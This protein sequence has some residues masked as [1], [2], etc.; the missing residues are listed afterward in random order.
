MSNILVM[1]KVVSHS[2]N[3]DQFS[4]IYQTINSDPQNRDLVFICGEERL[5]YHQAVVLKH[6]TFLSNL[7]KNFNNEI[8]ITLDNVNPG[9][10]RTLM[11]CIYSGLSQM[12]SSEVLYDVERVHQMLGFHI[13]FSVETLIVEE[14]ATL[15][16]EESST[17]NVV[18]SESF[19]VN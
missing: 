5:A 7:V 8:I 14:S 15:N 3:L 16:V 17:L 6:S 12:L 10:L 19:N 13:Y 11:N 18:E 1:Q 4:G 9:I 2:S